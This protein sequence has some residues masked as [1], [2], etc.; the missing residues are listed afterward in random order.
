MLSSFLIRIKNQMVGIYRKAKQLIKLIQQYAPFLDKI[1]P[2]LGV[3]VG[4]VAGIADNVADGI[5]NVYEDYDVA[6]KKK[7]NY[8]LSQG[9]RSFFKPSVT[10]TLTK[11]YGGLHPRLKLKELE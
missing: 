4:S 11:D 8:G 1:V 7:E 2:G 3:S 6:Q 9:L 10:N 5:N